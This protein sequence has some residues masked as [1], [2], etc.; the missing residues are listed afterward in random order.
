MMPRWEGTHLRRDLWIPVQSPDALQ[1]IFWSVLARTSRAASATRSASAGSRTASAIFSRRGARQAGRSGCTARES[2]CS[3]HTRRARDNDRPK[4]A[5]RL[6][7]V[8][9]W[10][11][12]ASAGADGSAITA[13]PPAS[14]IGRVS[15]RA[16][17]HGP[18]S[19][20]QAG[21]LAEGKYTPANDRRTVKDA[22]DSWLRLAVDGADNKTGAPL[23][24]TTRALYSMT[25]RTR[26]E[27][28]LG[29]TSTAE[30]RIRG[31]RDVE[32]RAADGRCRTENR[33]QRHGGSLAGYSATRIKV[34]VD[35]SQPALPD[36]STAEVLA[37]GA[38]L[39]GRRHRSDR[40]ACRPE[41][42]LIIVTA[43]STGLRFG[44]LAGLRWCD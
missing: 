38:R 8:D 17:P 44:E 15:T 42:A 23:R 14:G 4:T 41:A 3:P 33:H 31:D 29:F 19:W 26:L 43:A 10:H 18:S 12:Y 24:P 40:R 28:A 25:W 2:T 7:E 36:V 30:H 21:D 37:Q 13:T 9:R 16:R 20:P 35:L 6:S 1:G 27:G 11:A 22:Y 5:K 39:H 34:Q 32:A